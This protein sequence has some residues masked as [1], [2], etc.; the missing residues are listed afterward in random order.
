M[1]PKHVL[2]ALA[3]MA[4]MSVATVAMFLMAYTTVVRPY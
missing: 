4:G 2:I 3:I 1:S